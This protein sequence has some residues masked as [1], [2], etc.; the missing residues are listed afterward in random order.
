MS[1]EVKIPEFIEKI[2]FV[3]DIHGVY[4]NLLAVTEQRPDI[5]HWFCAGDIVD[6]FMPPHYNLPTVRL[7]MKLK[8]PS[9]RGNHDYNITR[10]SLEIFDDEGQQY[11]RE[12]PLYLDILFGGLKIRIYH[13][14]PESLDDY[15]PDNAQ[16][17]TYHSLFG[18]VKADIIV[19]GHTHRHYSKQYTG[20]RFIN[21]G[22]LG[23]PNEKPTFCVMDKSGEVEFMFL[24]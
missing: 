19:L 3:S 15:I 18:H 12:L 21:P 11:L 14:T 24:N 6:M 10:D 5:Q 20:M 16:G 1:D 8:I 4:E 13:A 17:E 9:V 7:M 2:G 23:I 22:S